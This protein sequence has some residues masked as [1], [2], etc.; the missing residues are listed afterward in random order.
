LRIKKSN[1][2]FQSAYAREI[3]RQENETNLGIMLTDYINLKQISSLEDSS[4]CSCSR[5]HIAYFPGKSQ[6]LIQQ[7][8]EIN[9]SKGNLFHFI[10]IKNL[11]SEQVIRLLVKAELFLDL[12]YF[13]GKDRLPREA[14][15]LNCPVLLA[16]RGSARYYEDFQLEDRYLLDLALLSPISTF[17][18]IIK[19]ITFGKESNLAA[20]KD[21][22]NAVLQEK[23]IFTQE[24]RKFIS[25]ISN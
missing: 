5:N 3:F 20:Q 4:F 16:K 11:N 9:S 8:L 18:A 12:G 7:V 15:I 19:T 22:K 1:Y 21:F 14:I 10:P 24:V 17:D 23:D 13:P 25:F 2:L 6:N